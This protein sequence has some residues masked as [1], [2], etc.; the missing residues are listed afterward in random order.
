MPEECYSNS[1]FYDKWINEN[2]ERH[3]P[4]IT[5]YENEVFI[6]SHNVVLTVYDACGCM[7][8]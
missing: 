4:E 7:R 2:D 8:I 5:D 6:G 3:L 1:S